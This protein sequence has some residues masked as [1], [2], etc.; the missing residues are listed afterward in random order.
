M[1]KI[2][3]ALLFLAIFSLA[4]AHLARAA[5]YVIEL[6][7]G[8]RVLTDSYWREGDE[9]KFN[10][11]N[12]EVGVRT[13]NIRRITKKDGTAAHPA[14]PEKAEGSTAPE[15]TAVPGEAE[16]SATA[17]EQT[18]GQTPSPNSQFL[19]EFEVHKQ[20]FVLVPTMGKDELAAYSKE[21]DKFRNKVL[22]AGQGAA[23]SEQI[24]EIYKMYDVIE[25]R[26]KSFN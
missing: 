16:G 18:A 22:Q 8:S 15:Q 17:P 19:A 13:A 7:N 2:H 12:G 21:L 1:R 23:L 11:V 9:I 20:K 6:T 14:A 26:Y 5:Y 3:R 24:Q 25:A 10:Y 4:P